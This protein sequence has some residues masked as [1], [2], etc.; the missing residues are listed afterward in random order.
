MEHYT[1]SGYVPRGIQRPLVGGGGVS[2][3]LFQLQFF[4][5]KK[6]RGVY[7]FL[8]VITLRVVV[9]LSPKIVINLTRFY[10][11]LPYIGEPFRFSG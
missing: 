8:G 1:S 7:Y 3:P 2:N 10:E 6:I 11:K 4:K 9:V 5:E